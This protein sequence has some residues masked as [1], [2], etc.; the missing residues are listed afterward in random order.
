M[1][2]D[3]LWGK[4]PFELEKLELFQNDLGIYRVKLV[5]FSLIDSNTILF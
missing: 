3:E 5:D 2:E 4:L 1:E